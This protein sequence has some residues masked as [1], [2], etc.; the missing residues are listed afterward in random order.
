[1]TRR[2]SF[3]RQFFTYWGLWALVALAAA[4]FALNIAWIDATSAARLAK[5]GADA[6][7]TVI[8]LNMTS[9][10]SNNRTQH[11]YEVT[12]QFT[13]DGAAQEGQKIVSE[14][15]YRGLKT[16][17]IIPVRYWTRDPGLTE[18]EPGFH[19]RQALIGQIVATVAAVLTLIFATLGWRWAA[20]ARWM[21]RNGIQVEVTVTRLAGSWFNFGKNSYYRATWADPRGEG[22]SRLHRGKHL[23]GVGTTITVLTDLAGLRASLWEGDL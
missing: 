21:V 15:F 6:Q 13:V 9:T 20:R 18:I 7:A 19:A 12:Y 22:R 23:P 14:A 17:D 5:E 4:A 11:H 8:G 16:G 10:R 3:L 1:M 2:K